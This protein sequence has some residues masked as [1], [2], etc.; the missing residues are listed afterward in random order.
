[1]PLQKFDTPGFESDLTDN[2]KTAWSNKINSWIEDERNNLGSPLDKFFF[3]ELQH[4]E[5]ENGAIAPITWEGFPRFWKLQFPNDQQKRWEASEKLYKLRGVNCRY[6]DEYLEWHSYKVNGKLS[7]VIFSCEG[8]EYWE[9]IA[10]VDEQKLLNLYRTY[11]SPNVQINDLFTIVAGVKT[12]NRSNKWNLTD[13]IVH[14]THPANT[15][16]AEINLAAQATILRKKGAVNPV[17]DTH[18]LICCSGYGAPDRFSDPTIGAGVNSFVRQGFSVTLNNP[19][20][21]YIHKLDTSGIEVPN[22]FQIKDFWK[23]TRGDK[24]KGMILRAEFSVPVGS[25]ISLED[26]KIGGN[27]LKYGAQLAEIIEMVLYGKAFKLENNLPASENCGNH[28]EAIASLSA[29]RN[30]DFVNEKITLQK[31]E[32]KLGLRVTPSTF[33]KI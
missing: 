13:G 27:P 5:T 3:N 29:N 4:P 6:Q 9:H 30:I 16:G 8:P 33:E 24:G 17:T 7:K 18:D 1:M 12:Y 22:G 28:C 25:N 32:G 21:L 26:V 10:Q 20:G 11:I 14:L 15:L 19:I 23:V 31:S 2:Q